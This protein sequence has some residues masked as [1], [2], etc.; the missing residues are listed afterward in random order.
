MDSQCCVGK[1]ANITLDPTAPEYNDDVLITLCRSVGKAIDSVLPVT[2][3]PTPAATLK[4]TPAATP[5]P[6]PAATPMPTL[7]AATPTT[8]LPAATSEPWLRQTEVTTS[9]KLLLCPYGGD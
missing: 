6:S 3:E 5:K 1:K 2:P 9:T 7:P 4:P 8:T